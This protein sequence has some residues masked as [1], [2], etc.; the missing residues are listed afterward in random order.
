MKINVLIFGASGMVGKGALLES[1][2]SN[3]VN[4]VLVIGRST[5]GNSH[6]KL[7]EIIHADMSDLTPLKEK[8]SSINSCFFCLGM[9]AMGLSE[10]KYMKLT[11]ELT[12]N[13]A[14]I[15]VDINKDITFIYV[16]G[17]G[18]DS[19]EK[20]RIM[21]ARVKGKTE[22]AL[23]NLPFKAAYMFRPGYIQPVK[24]VK[25]RVPLYRFFYFLFSWLYPL[26]K[27][28]FPKQLLNSAQLGQAMI[29]LSLSNKKSG[30]YESSDI[31]ELSMQ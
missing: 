25:T 24:G 20:G 4:S 17:S 13:A 10:A 5:C 2:E 29:T 14:Q 3:N 15:L 6:S 21:W 31:N 7:T 27:L 9:S 8:F 12:I 19:T 11:Y 1:L 26:L 16:S 28:L 18:T 30:I 22:N 23:M